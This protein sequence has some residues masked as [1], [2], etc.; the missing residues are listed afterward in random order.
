M[1]LQTYAIPSAAGSG[2]ICLN[3]AA[4]RHA[5]PGDIVIIATFVW[6]SDAEA[7]KFQPKVVFVDSGNQIRT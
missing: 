5:Q 7:G 3:G 1:R 4:A 2:E 6:L